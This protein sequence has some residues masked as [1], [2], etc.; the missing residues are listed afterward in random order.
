MAQ[1]D[2]RVKYL[3]GSPQPRPIVPCDC[4]APT[5]PGLVLDHFVGS[6]TTP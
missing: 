3:E 6:G 5:R 4:D 1:V 2:A